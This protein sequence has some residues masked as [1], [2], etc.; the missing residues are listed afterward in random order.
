MSST[1]TSRRA[2]QSEQREATAILHDLAG[3]MQKIDGLACETHL[4]LG[5][6]FQVIGNAAE[7]FDADLVVMGS[8]RRQILRKVLWGLLWSGR[9][10]RASA[11]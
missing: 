1:M 7:T 9:S 3:T 11:P 10:D 5:D 4:A 2:L 6:P 8:R